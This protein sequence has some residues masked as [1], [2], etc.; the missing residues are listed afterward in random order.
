VVSY[1]VNSGANGIWATMMNYD[2]NPSGGALDPCLNSC[3]Y[4]SSGTAQKG[5][6]LSEIHF[7]TYYSPNWTWVAKHELG[8]TLG[9]QDHFCYYGLMDTT[10]CYQ[11]DATTAEKDRVDAI[12]GR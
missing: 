6:D 5:Y 8:H 12:H 7:N 9:L 1:T 4:G 2:Q 3:S 10:A 11:V